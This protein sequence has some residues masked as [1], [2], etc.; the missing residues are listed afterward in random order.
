MKVVREERAWLGH[1][2]ITIQ[3]V[4]GLKEATGN[5]GQW[6]DSDNLIQIDASLRG[7]A[8]DAVLWHE[9]IHAVSDAYALRLTETKVR[10]LE[11]GLMTITQ[12]FRMNPVKETEW[13]V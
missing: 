12:P 6:S 4:D 1:H 9:A 5:D 7:P 2:P 10:V 13:G 11:S 8:F 3:V